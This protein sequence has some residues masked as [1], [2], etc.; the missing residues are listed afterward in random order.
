[1]KS[2]IGLSGQIAQKINTIDNITKFNLDGI[3]NNMKQLAV[4][5]NVYRN[6]AVETTMQLQKKLEPLRAVS[7]C[8]LLDVQKK[9]QKIGLQMGLASQAV[10]SYSFKYDKI[11][12]NINT[13]REALITNNIQ[14][15]R[16]VLTEAQADSRLLESQLKGIKQFLSSTTKFIYRD[17]L[18]HFD[19]LNENILK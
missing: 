8:G 6:I 13:P 3:Q 1:M 19:S 14:G 17:K 7:K 12:S 2:L 15:I 10:Q 5:S 11:I 9:V 4:A 16:S 18:I